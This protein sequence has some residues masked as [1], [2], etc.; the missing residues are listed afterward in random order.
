MNSP[1]LSFSVIITYGEMNRKM[2]SL[3]TEIKWADKVF[4][5]IM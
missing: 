2:K 5:F 3:N 1:E 4:H